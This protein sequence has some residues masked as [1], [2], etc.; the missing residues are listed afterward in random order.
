MAK[1]DGR[2]KVAVLLMDEMWSHDLANI[3]QVFGI[4]EDE[5]G[6]DPCDLMFVAASERV[7][8]DHGIMVKTVPFQAYHDAP[9]L[10]C[11]PGFS[12]PR[13]VHRIMDEGGF[14]EWND[15]CNWL[16]AQYSAGAEI[17]A[18]GS[19][20]LVLARAGLL[21]GVR[22]TAHWTYAE[23]FERSY[24]R[25]ALRTTQMIEYDSEHRIWT[26]AGGV[27]GLDLCQ[28]MLAKA[29]GISSARVITKNANLWAPR[30]LETRQDPLLGPSNAVDIR[31]GQE[32]LTL[33]DTIRMSLGEEWTLARTA[34]C[35]GM[36]PR[37]F[38]RQFQRVM[39]QAPSRWLLS[40]RLCVAC[41]LLERSDLTVSL[42]ASKVGMGSDD[43]LRKHFISAYGM[44]PIA[45]RRNYRGIESSGGGSPTE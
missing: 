31:V 36:S 33:V 30:S 5:Q 21:D 7:E 24:P 10:L 42:I 19:G 25:A 14:D 34:R 26:C 38:Q 41:E 15:C 23:V 44:T 35:V 29:V 43:L 1:K 37:T 27:S 28:N 20:P 22:F 16:H 6:V 2:L 17:G 40:E 13:G 18:M 4:P 8:L 32:I 9:D 45:Y 12:Y 39:G 11:I 3:I